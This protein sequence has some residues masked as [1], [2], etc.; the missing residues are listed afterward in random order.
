MGRVMGTVCCS[1]VTLERFVVL[2]GDLGILPLLE[3]ILLCSTP[4]KV[5]KTSL[6]QQNLLEI[7]CIFVHKGVAEKSMA[8]QDPVPRKG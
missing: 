1:L 8:I 2:W 5:L 7:S 3:V 6:G 4:W